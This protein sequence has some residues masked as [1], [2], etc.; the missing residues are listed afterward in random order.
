[1]RKRNRKRI[2][3]FESKER[4]IPHTKRAAVCISVR[5]K[6]SFLCVSPFQIKLFRASFFS[7]SSLSP[8]GPPLVFRASR[9]PFPPVSSFSSSSSPV[10]FHP[11]PFSLSFFFLFVST[12]SSPPFLPLIVETLSSQ[13][14]FSVLLPAGVPR[15]YTLAS[16]NHPGPPPGNLFK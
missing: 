2:G 14:P 9:E 10:S 13:T 6:K 1:M 8:H 15:P 3:R 11:V 12:N 4:E 7:P 16:T 5:V